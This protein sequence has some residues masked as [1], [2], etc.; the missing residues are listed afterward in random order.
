M[1]IVP[2]RDSS[3]ELGATAL[4]PPGNSR[5]FDGRLWESGLCWLY[6]RRPGVPVIWIGPVSAAGRTAAMYACRHC[7]AELEFMVD[8]DVE[9]TDSLDS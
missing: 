4:D 3:Q 1:L 2:S 6:C 5:N 9:R 8:R 7:I